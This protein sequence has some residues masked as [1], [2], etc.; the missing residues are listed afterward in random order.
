MLTLPKCYK[1]KKCAIEE[2]YDMEKYVLDKLY[3]LL[4]TF[5]IAEL[6]DLWKEK[7]KEAFKATKKIEDEPEASNDMDE[8]EENFVRRLMKGSRK[9]KGIQLWNNWSVCF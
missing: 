3:S 2:I 9:C 1:P 6:D 8:I 4:S 5:E 7:K